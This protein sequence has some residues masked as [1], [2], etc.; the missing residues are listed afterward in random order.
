MT[1]K[2]KRSKK[3]T[4]FSTHEHTVTSVTP[5]GTPVESATVLGSRD[6]FHKQLEF[7]AQGFLVVVHN[8]T[9][10]REEYRT[11]GCAVEPKVK[12]FTP[13]QADIITVALTDAVNA[14]H[15]CGEA[16]KHD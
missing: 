12:K 5:T 11:P 10:E 7:E 14:V 2:A 4:A 1:A 3:N 13:E 15:V 16:C 9:L 6:A 8:D